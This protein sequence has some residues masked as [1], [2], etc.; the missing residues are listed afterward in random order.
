MAKKTIISSILLSNTPQ[1]AASFFR[2][3]CAPLNSAGEECV[4]PDGQPAFPVVEKIEHCRDRFGGGAQ[5]DQ[6]CYAVS[7]VDAEEKVIIP[8]TQFC[9]A[10]IVV[11]DS[12]DD[13]NVPS[14]P[15]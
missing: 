13:A 4:T 5:V 1:F 8:I 7:F 10:T 11:L 2:I 15:Q 14:M 12:N 3:G 6:P 9:Q